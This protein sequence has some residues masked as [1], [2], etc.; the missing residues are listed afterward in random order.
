MSITVGIHKTFSNL[1]SD[2][3]YMLKYYCSN[4][5]EK[6][7]DPKTTTWYIKDNGA[8]LLKLKLWFTKMISY[9]QDNEIACV[10]SQSFQIPVFRVYTEIATYCLQTPNIIPPINSSQPFL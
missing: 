8:F 1:K 3:N 7:S 5:L 4:Q 6:I 9:D 10:L 2:S